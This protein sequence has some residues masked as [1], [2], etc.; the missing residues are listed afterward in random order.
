MKYN[1]IK[2]LYAIRGNRGVELNEENAK[3]IILWN[4]KL[5]LK[6]IIVTLSKDTVSWKDEDQMKREKFFLKL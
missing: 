6:R 1:D 2:F 5:K 3:R 4:D